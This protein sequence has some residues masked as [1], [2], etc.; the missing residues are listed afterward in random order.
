MRL[1][2]G[3]TEEDLVDASLEETMVTAYHEI[4]RESEALGKEADLRTAALVIAI[5]QIAR[6]YMQS[7]I[8]P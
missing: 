5:H 2:H 8:F 3:A 4:R 7:G 1:A 6:S